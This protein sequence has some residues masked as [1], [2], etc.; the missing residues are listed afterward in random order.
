VEDY[1]APIYR[2][3]A[4]YVIP[5]LSRA[6]PT[7]I[8]TKFES[9]QFNERFGQNAVI[10]I[11]FTNTAPGSFSNEHKFGGLA[12][13]PAKDHESQLAEIAETL[14][15]RLIEDRNRKDVA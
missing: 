3:E 1:L 5:L 7:R 13:D 14:S 2:T 11:R 9:D 10:P 6:Y 4:R 8:W 15:Q 12:F